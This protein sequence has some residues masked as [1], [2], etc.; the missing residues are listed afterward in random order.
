MPKQRK[1]REVN[2]LVE[3]RDI[4]QTGG[5]IINRTK[6]ITSLLHQGEC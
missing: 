2:S 4:E 3:I 5:F 6:Y 1:G